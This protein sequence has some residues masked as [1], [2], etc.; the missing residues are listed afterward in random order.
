MGTWSQLF[1]LGLLIGL[2]TSATVVA[3]TTCPHDINVTV[4]YNCMI[5]PDQDWK[6]VISQQ[7]QNLVFIG[8]A[9]CAKIHV[10]MSVPSTHPEL[11]YDQLE[12][13]LFE[14]REVVAS[15]LHLQ[16]SPGTGGTVISQ[17]H[18]NSFEYPGLHL[19][20]LLAQV[21]SRGGMFA[22]NTYWLSPLVYV[23][24]ECQVDMPR[25]ACSCISIQKA[26]CTTGIGQV[27]TWPNKACS[28]PQ[29]LLGKKSC[30]PSAR[31]QPSLGQACSLQKLV[32]YGSTFGGLVRRTCN[33][34]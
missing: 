4:I 2:W 27:G 26:W 18:E 28:M 7:L 29:S 20:W 10:V 30:T 25:H 33:E 6:L 14:G 5:W 23:Y 1:A 12:H 32:G 19:L 17:V 34:S 24:R 9:E 15:I 21:M 11:A 31:I 16:H 13:L 22:L 3:A 8:L